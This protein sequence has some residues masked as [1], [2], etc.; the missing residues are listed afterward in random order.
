M[1][2][3]VPI[4]IQDVETVENLLHEMKERANEADQQGNLFLLDCFA[5]IV[6]LVAPRVE[7]FRARFEREE[8][9]DINRRRKALHEQ[10][11]AGNNGSTQQ[12]A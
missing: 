7:Q 1:A 4:T 3:T 6:K 8:R 10:H 12:S 2:T 11:R 9:A 5:D